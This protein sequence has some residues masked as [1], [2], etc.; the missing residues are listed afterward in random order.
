MEGKTKSTEL[1][2]S[3]ELNYDREV[4]LS[5]LMSTKAGVKGLVDSGISSVPRIFKVQAEQKHSEEFNCNNKQFQVPIINL[6]GFQGER[7]QEII[8]DILHASKTWGIFQVVCHGVPSDV[9]KNMLRSV[10]EFHE[11]PREL[12]EEFYSHDS[13]RKVWYYMTVHPVRKAALWKDTIACQFE[14]VTVDYQALPLICRKPM[15]E[16]VEHV[17]KLKREL[18]KLLCEALGLDSDHLEQMECMKAR[19]LVG[20]YYPSCPEPELTMGTPKHSDPYFFTI[21]LQGHVDG[22][23]ALHQNQWINVQPVDGALVA[24]I[25]D[26]LQLI[27]NDILKSAEHRVLATRRGPRLSAACFFYPTAVNQKLRFGPLKELLSDSSPALYNE[28]THVEYLKHYS[29][30]GSCGSKPLPDFRL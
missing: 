20:H 3:D 27:S 21:L 11:Q 2:G 24:I 17:N 9:M 30:H 12:K 22:L 23:Q 10:S 6:E 28:V 15:S 8:D 14:D 29:L 4:E 16:F 7:R 19:K 26:M 25:G 1:V 5:E 18:S 13:T